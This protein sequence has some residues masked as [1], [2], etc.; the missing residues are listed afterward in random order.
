MKPQCKHEFNCSVAVFMFEDKPGNGSAELKGECRHCGAPLIFQG[1]RGAGSS[2][3]AASVDRHE[4]RAP[5]TFGLDAVFQPG[6]D[7]RITG[8][9][10]IVTGR[11]RN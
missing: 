8:P 10:L 5:V 4:L 9:E 1:P 7:M 3:A 6:P 11:E 2:Q